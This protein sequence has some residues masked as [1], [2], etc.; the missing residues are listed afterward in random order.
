MIAEIVNRT[1]TSDARRVFG[2]SFR[3]LIPAKLTGGAREAQFFNDRSNPE[4]AKTDAERYAE[5][6]FLSWKKLG[7]AFAEIP[8]MRQEAVVAWRKLV[9]AKL[10]D[11]A[12][13]GGFVKAVEAAIR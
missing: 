2:K 11:P 12:T 8:A 3:V 1:G 13:G 6:R 4:Q 10:T 7:H 5:D 9:D